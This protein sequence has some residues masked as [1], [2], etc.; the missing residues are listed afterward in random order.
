MKKHSRKPSRQSARRM[1]QLA[2]YH[3]KPKQSNYHEIA[4]LEVPLSKTGL[5]YVTFTCKGKD[6][7]FLLDT[8][9][10]ISYVESSAI[11]DMDIELKKCNESARG[12][13]GNQEIG[14]YCS[15]VLETPSTVTVIDLPVSNFHDAFTTVEQECGVTLHGLL[16]NNFLQASKYVIDY[17]KMM[18]LK[19]KSK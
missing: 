13:T 11:S 15:L 17:D 18:I 19:R 8:G 6:M 9:S 3:R 12:I 1:T 4:S 14:Y 7:N 2:D 10:N 16:G 5:I